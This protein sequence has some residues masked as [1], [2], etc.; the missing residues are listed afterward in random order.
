MGG[1]PFQIYDEMENL[2]IEGRNSYAAGGMSNVWGAQL[3]RYTNDDFA[4]V[5]D[6][7]IDASDLERYYEELEK[8]IGI[9]GEVDDMHYF[10]GGSTPEMRSFKMVPAADR[11]YSSYNHLQQKKK[12]PPELLLGRP[13]LALAT[14]HENDRSPY[15]F[16]ETEFFS[17]NQTG[18]YSARI[19]LDHLLK[20]SNFSYIGGYHL[21]S[22]KEFPDYVEIELRACIGGHARRLRT[23]HLLLGCGAMQTAKLVLQ[24][25]G[26]YDRTL[27]FIDHPPTLVPFLIPHTIGSKLPVKSYP[28]QL[29][30]TLPKSGR[31][32]MIT[33]Y[34][35]G[36]M[37]WSDL[38]SEIPLPMSAVVRIMGA[39]LGGMLVAQIWQKAMP[40]P[41]NR[42][43]LDADGAIKISYKN[44]DYCSAINDLL[45]ALRKLGAY[46]FRKL[47]SKSK[48]GWGFHYAGCLPM[49]HK[50]LE[51]ETH[52]D[53][54]LWNS[55]RVRI[56]DGSVMPSLPAKN[57]SLTLMANSARIAVDT[58][59]CGY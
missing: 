9:S 10:L 1:E 19:T 49:R 26:Q 33:F 17:S 13:R 20:R 35:P 44:N 22:W 3:L 24:H 34:Y 51:F 38:V 37:L 53:G 56:I 21:V 15:S 18:L 4:D 41:Y 27:P 42:L 45:P 7:P 5:G 57:H 52:V 14:S 23:K 36:G 28:I 29:I 32:D 11:I 40:L 43:R 46:S 2:L 39:L 47:S 6:W 59:K 31:R 58:I 12:I 54:R 30:G 16:G 55:R 50:P 25:H 48:P 8:H